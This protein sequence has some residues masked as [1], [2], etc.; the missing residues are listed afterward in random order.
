MI[1]FIR[2]LREGGHIECSWYNNN[3][4]R[5]RHEISNDNFFK[6][7]V[8]ETDNQYGYM[9]YAIEDGHHI[10]DNWED[11]HPEVLE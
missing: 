2:S 5:Y 6:L 3:G 11:K 7:G 9:R 8:I 10:I 1:T 4:K